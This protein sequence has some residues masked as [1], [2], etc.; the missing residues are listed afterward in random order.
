[1]IKDILAAIEAL[2]IVPAEFRKIVLTEVEGKRK[3][4]PPPGYKARK[5]PGPK[6]GFKKK[7]A[8]AVA[9]ATP[10][11]VVDKDKLAKLAKLKAKTA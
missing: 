8:A 11:K 9:E 5:K 4:G 3:P 7:K 10:T 1:M 2:R 6:P